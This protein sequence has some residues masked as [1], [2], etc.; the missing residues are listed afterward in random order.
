MFPDSLV[1]L[2]VIVLEDLAILAAQSDDVL[3]EGVVVSVNGIV[4]EEGW[5]QHT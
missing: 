1:G 3:E 4:G 5:R 2:G